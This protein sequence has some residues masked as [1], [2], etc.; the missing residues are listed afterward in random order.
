M[1]QGSARQ[2]D[3]EQQIRRQREGGRGRETDRVGAATTGRG[4]GREVA[5]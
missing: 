4:K 5:R 1:Q 2:R 3:Q